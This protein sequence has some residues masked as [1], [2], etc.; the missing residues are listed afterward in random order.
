MDLLKLKTKAGTSVKILSYFLRKWYINSSIIDRVDSFY[1]EFSVYFDERNM[2]SIPYMYK[3]ILKQSNISENEKKLR[4]DRIADIITR[5]HKLRNDCELL[6]KK[7]KRKLFSKFMGDFVETLK[8]CPKLAKEMLDLIKEHSIPIPK[9]YATTRLI[10]NHLVI[11]L[12]GFLNNT[13]CYHSV[14]ITDSKLRDQ[15]L[16][17]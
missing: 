3:E 7:R 6:I 2:A 13:A 8:E 15:F 11:S 1:T 12:Y 10:F 14:Y 17:P 9:E 5:W 4:R 16:L